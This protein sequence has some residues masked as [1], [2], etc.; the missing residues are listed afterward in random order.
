MHLKIILLSA[1]AIPLSSFH[2]LSLHFSL[3]SGPIDIAAISQHLSPTGMTSYIPDRLQSQNYPDRMA[4]TATCC[5]C[6]VTLTFQCPGSCR[7]QKRKRLSHPKM[8]ERHGGSVECKVK[9]SM[10]PASRTSTIPLDYCVLPQLITTGNTSSHF[11][12]DRILKCLN[13]LATIKVL[14]KIF[15]TS[16]AL[17]VQD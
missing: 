2:E 4:P 6:S 3:T 5:P 16:M 11:T 8:D 17:L 1:S 9:Y 7:E 14:F 13:D 15:Y 12:L 10:H